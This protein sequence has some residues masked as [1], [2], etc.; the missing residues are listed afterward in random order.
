MSEPS[1]QKHLIVLPRLQGEPDVRINTTKIYAVLGRIE[2]VAMVTSAKAP[3]LMTAFNKAYLELGRWATVILFRKAQAKMDLDKIYA[4][5]VL[6]KVPQVIATKGLR[7]SESVREAVANQDD[8]YLKARDT[9]DRYIALYEV[10]KHQM[11]SIEMAYTGAKKVLGE[12]NPNLIDTR[13]ELTGSN[14]AE[15]DEDSPFGVAR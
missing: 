11:K 1:I 15:Q 6:E 3:E 14:S 9:F 5:I 4:R 7:E 10:V 12:H 2:E 13:K 8:Q